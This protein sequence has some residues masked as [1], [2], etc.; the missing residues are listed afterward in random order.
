MK[1]IDPNLELLP[2]KKPQAGPGIGDAVPSTYGYRGY[3]DALE[4]YTEYHGAPTT[5]TPAWLGA[6][7]RNL[8]DTTYDLLTLAFDVRFD[9]AAATAARVMEFDVRVARGGMGFNCSSQFNVETGLWQITDVNGNWVNT[10]WEFPPF[11]AWQ[12]HHVEIS[13]WFDWVKRLYSV[14]SARIETGNAISSVYFTP[15]ALQGISAT[16]LAWADSVNVQ[17]QQGLNASRIPVGY[18]Q[19]MKNINLIWSV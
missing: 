16:P 15:P 14:T 2:W 11:S 17:V 8:P 19:V 10:T 9:G 1:L 5:L 18:S 7:S 6:I 4:F 12:K 3:N 13:Y